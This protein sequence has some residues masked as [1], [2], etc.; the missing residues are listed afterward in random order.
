VLGEAT[1]HQTELRPAGSPKGVRENGE[2][3]QEA[4]CFLCGAAVAVVQRGLVDTRY[5][6]PGSYEI[7]QCV[8]CGLEQTHPVPSLPEL[9]ELYETEYNFGGERGTRYTRWREL[10]LF[11]FL[12][13]L[14]T[15][16]D[17]DICFY[18]RRGPGRLLDIGCNEGRGLKMY[19]RNGFQPE[20]LELNRKAAAVA[21]EA[22][23]EVHACLLEEFDSETRYEV[24]VLSNVLEHSLDPRL[25][26]QDV[27]RILVD[28]GQV[29]ISCPNSRSWLRRVFGR[30]W[31]N[32][33]VPFH[34]FHFSPETLRRL[35]AETGFDQIET[36]Q[37]T[38]A[39]WVAQSFIARF[40]GREGKQSRQLRNPLLILALMMVSRFVLFPALWIGN[41]LG[42]G[43]CLLAVATKAS[44]L[45]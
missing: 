3:A 17:G 15:H 29:W 22:G 12:N 41:R 39:L 9:K 5:G 26:L 23:F 27:R 35:L 14:W 19:A 34:L 13:R 7:H 30:F 28:G 4:S 24:A 18:R 20:G 40:C 45:S 33:H 16:I 32:W 42:Q 25:M 43:D 38:P 1:A 37:T 10:F 11:S 31:I 21:R 8:H 6:T 36:R 2:A 44:S